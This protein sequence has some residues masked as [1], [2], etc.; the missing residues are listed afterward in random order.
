MQIGSETA[1]HLPKANGLLHA[2]VAEP[3]DAHDSKSCG[4]NPMR[5]RFSPEAFLFERS[6]KKCLFSMNACA[7]KGEKG[8]RME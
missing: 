8:N 6:E 3:V 1:R 7:I 4:G 5:V 2:S